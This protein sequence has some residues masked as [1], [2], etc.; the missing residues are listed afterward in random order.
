MLRNRQRA[1]RGQLGRPPAIVAVVFAGDYRVRTILL[2][3]LAYLR[4]LGDDVVVTKHAMQP[5]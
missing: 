1:A 4:L 3:E 2:G 5:L